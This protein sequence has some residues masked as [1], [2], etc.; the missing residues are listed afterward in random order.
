ML[1]A[2]DERGF[3]QSFGKVATELARAC[4]FGQDRATKRHILLISKGIIFG[5]MIA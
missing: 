4:R 1:A 5:M 2:K 3:R